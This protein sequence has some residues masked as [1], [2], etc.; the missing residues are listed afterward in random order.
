MPDRPP[1]PDAG[2]EPERVLGALAEL[3]ARCAAVLVTHA[4][5]DHIGAVGAV[6]GEATSPVY[7]S[8]GDRDVVAHINDHLWPGFG[9]YV[10]HEPEG[11]GRLLDPACDRARFFHGWEQIAP[12]LHAG[13]L[14]NCAPVLKLAPGAVR[15][16]T[17]LAAV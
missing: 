17:N 16:E 5:L 3:G 10:E 13:G 6:A 11:G 4:H 9:P 7:T 12:A 8:A 15:I 2:E 14:S 1:E